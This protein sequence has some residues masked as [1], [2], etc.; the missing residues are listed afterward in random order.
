MMKDGKNKTLI[1]KALG[2]TTASVD[3]WFLRHIVYP[4]WKAW[5]DEIEKDLAE[6]L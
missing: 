1:A 4:E 6:A 2:V 5:S 3:I